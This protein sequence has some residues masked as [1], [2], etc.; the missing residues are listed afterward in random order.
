M[1][2][3]CRTLAP[4]PLRLDP[5]ILNCGRGGRREKEGRGRLRTA[6]RALADWWSLEDPLGQ[7]VSP[8]PGLSQPGG[9][10]RAFVGRARRGRFRRRGGAE[11]RCGPLA[12]RVREGDSNFPLPVDEREEETASS[13]GCFLLSPTIQYPE[14]CGFN[15]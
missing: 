12:V 10:F 7:G 1:Q 6:N 15:L 13:V 2:E 9:E 11:T 8:A 3:S 14:S 4:G 5:A